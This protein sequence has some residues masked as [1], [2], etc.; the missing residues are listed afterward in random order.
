AVADDLHAGRTP[1]VPSNSLTVADLCN[2][3]LT[4][5]LQKKQAGELSPL[6]FCT[7][8]LI[9]DLLVAEFGKGGLAEGSTA[10]EFQAL[11][12]KMAE[13]WGPVRLANAISWTKSVFKFAVDN[14]LLERLPRYGSEFKK[15]DKS[16]LRRHRAQAVP[17]MLEATDL[18]QLIT[19]ATIPF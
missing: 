9:T 16:V 11:R 1:R 7:Y 4:A 12:A 8:K 13:R 2:R 19:A 6:M 5:K 15:P 14:G 17:K 18:R 3:F 10:G